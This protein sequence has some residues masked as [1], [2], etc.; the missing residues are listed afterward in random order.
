MDC[1]NDPYVASRHP[2]PHPASPIA[3]LVANW[4][5][6]DLTFL[7]SRHYLPCGEFPFPHLRHTDRLDDVLP[8]P[9]QPMDEL[10]GVRWAKPDGNDIGAVISAHPPINM[11]GDAARSTPKKGLS[12]A[13]RT[14]R[15]YKD[16]ERPISGPVW[17]ALREMLRQQ[18]RDDLV[19]RI[20]NEIGAR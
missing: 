17:I 1:E 13:L 10:H 19:D 11:I 9:C 12:S 3:A 16:G 2:F 8:F 5:L 4:T 18:G 6:V 7:D 20:D 15:R 14:I